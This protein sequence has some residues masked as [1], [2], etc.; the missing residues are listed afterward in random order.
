MDIFI[1]NDVISV[2]IWSSFITTKKNS[3]QTCR[4][5]RM[6]WLRPQEITQSY[7]TKSIS[8]LKGLNKSLQ[9]P[10]DRNWLFLSKPFFFCHCLRWRCHLLK[11]TTAAKRALLFKMNDV[12]I[13]LL[14]KFFSCYIKKYVHI[15]LLQAS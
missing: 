14:S 7:M 5:T 12:I 13:L 6:N 10:G 1:R 3:K 15:T 8:P 4:A 11:T 2:L 9:I